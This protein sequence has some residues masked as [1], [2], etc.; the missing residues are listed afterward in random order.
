[1]KYTSQHPFKDP[2]FQSHEGNYQLK[3]TCGQDR[4][5]V[6]VGKEVQLAG[7]EQSGRVVLCQDGNPK[8]VV[9]LVE[10]QA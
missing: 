5:W 4:I 3:G 6:G 8:K 9:T 7:E 2:S 10:H 1:M